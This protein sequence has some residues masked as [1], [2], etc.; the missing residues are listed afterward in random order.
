[1]R[2]ATICRSSYLLDVAVFRAGAEEPPAHGINADDWHSPDGSFYRAAVNND[3]VGLM[4]L[5]VAILDKVLPGG[6]MPPKIHCFF[7]V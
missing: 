3:C 4:M 7:F 2:C 1:M 6:L 5:G